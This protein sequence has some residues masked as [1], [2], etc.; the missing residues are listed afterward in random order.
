MIAGGT[1]REHFHCD[2]RGK[3]TGELAKDFSRRA[4]DGTDSAVPKS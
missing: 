1:M 4:L 2:L 3:I